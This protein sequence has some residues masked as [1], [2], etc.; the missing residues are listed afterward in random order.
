MYLIY[1][2][3]IVPSS[4][5]T[6]SVNPNYPI[7]NVATEY[8]TQYYQAETGVTSATITFDCKELTDLALFN[9]NIVGG[10]ITV[11]G[12]LLTI[13][14]KDTVISQHTTTENLSV[15]DGVYLTINDGIVLT[16][17]PYNVDP[18]FTLISPSTTYSEDVRLDNI[19]VLSGVTMTIAEGVT[20][21]IDPD[22]NELEYVTFTFDIEVYRNN[23]NLDKSLFNLPTYL[24]D[25]SVTIEAKSSN[26]LKIG[27]ILA[28]VHTEYG[29]TEYGIDNEI[30]DW[31]FNT[32]TESGT[33]IY[34]KNYISRDM[35]FPVFSNK[36]QWENLL[37]DLD[38]HQ[39][40]KILYMGARSGVHKNIT[41]LD[42]VT[43]A[44]YGFM[45]YP[46]AKEER[47]RYLRYT[48]TMEET[49]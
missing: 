33:L 21:R 35:G 24:M 15:R 13:I 2:N 40:K 26:T 41:P 11:R 18:D 44:I 34:N 12:Q 37:F 47:G 3:T 4:L 43:Y 7:S 46:K 48:V 17:D 23:R 20:V 45:K 16:V 38:I 29:I 25:A 5:Q 32:R 42:A 27:T 31:G 6:T 19:R 30:K 39:G 36:D 14:D 49:K 22:V 10:R 1:D 9:T 8:V 28:G